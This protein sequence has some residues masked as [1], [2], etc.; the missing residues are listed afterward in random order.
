MVTLG[1]LRRKFHKDVKADDR[2]QIAGNT[3]TWTGVV[4]DRGEKFITEVKRVDLLE[5][6]G[7][8]RWETTLGGTNILNDDNKPMVVVGTMEDDVVFEVVDDIR[9]F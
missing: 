7:D 5:D 1:R 8:F 4:L 2:L 6:T 3:I 9:H